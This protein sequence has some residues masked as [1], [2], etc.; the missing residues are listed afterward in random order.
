MRAKPNSAALVQNGA[1][2]RSHSQPDRPT[3]SGWQWVANTRSSGDDLLP[4]GA[5]GVG[6]GAAIDQ[7]QP[8]PAFDPVVQ[9]PQIDVV[10]G[11]GQR[12]AQPAQA[13]RNVVHR[14][15]RGDAVAEGIT[16]LGF[17]RIHG[18]T[19]VVRQTL[20][21]TMQSTLTLT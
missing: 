18:E 21:A 8:V 1:W 16:E 15:G 19:F 17:E 11:E 5:G 4:G 2:K 10:E 12:H 7:R 13:G 6:A 14:A 3:W 20:Q 9:Q